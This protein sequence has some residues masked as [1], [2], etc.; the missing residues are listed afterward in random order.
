[1]QR[2]FAKP[3]YPFINVDL[4]TKLLVWSK[5]IIDPRYDP[6]IIRKDLCGNWMHLHEHGLQT[7]L[8]WEIDHVFPASLGGTDDIDNLQPLWWRNNRRKGDN[9]PWWG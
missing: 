5:G 8:G 2:Y 1:M 4:I 9:Y 6:Q 3:Q 7:Y